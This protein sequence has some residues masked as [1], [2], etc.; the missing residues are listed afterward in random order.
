MMIQWRDYSH[1]TI[2]SDTI[3]C[4]DIEVTSFW[5]HT[6]KILK[7]DNN[8]SDDFYNQECEKGSVVYIWMLGIDND[9]YYGREW[10]E[11]PEFLA[12][13]K[14]DAK[15]IRKKDKIY[16]YVHNLAYEFQFMQ[17]FGWE[18]DNV[19][20]RQVRKPMKADFDIFQF[21]C[22]YQLTHL[23]LDSW[24]K[25]L[26]IKKLVGELDYNML[27]SPLTPLFDYELDYCE[28]DIL[29]MQAGLKKYR[30]KYQHISKIPLTSTGEVRKVV[31]SIYH[32]DVSYLRHT[33]KCMPKTVE[34]YKIAKSVFGGGD[35]HAN[36]INVGKTIEHCKG[37]DLS[38]SYPF[39][40]ATGFFPMSRFLE[41][42]QRDNFDTKRFCFIFFI[43]LSDAK[44]R[45]TISYIARSRCISVK[46]GTYDNGRVVN[47]DE[48]YLYCTE[49]DL[50]YI[51]YFYDAKLE[52]ISVRRAIKG[53]LDKRYVE[54]ILELFND[55]TTL[56]GVAGYEDLY[57]QQKAYLNSLFGMMVTDI[58]M[59]EI[60][61]NNGEWT[62]KGQ[63]QVDIAESLEKL[64]KNWYKNI[65]S[66]YWGIYVTSQARA[67]LWDGIIAII[68]AGGSDDIIYYDTDSIK[69]AHPD[70]YEGIFNRLNAERYHKLV[71]SS[72]R[73]NIPIERYR[74]VKPDGYLSILGSWEN[75]GN[76]KKFAL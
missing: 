74:P 11:L 26:G 45:G 47:A 35:T 14:E 1:R 69:Y 42:N 56:K 30:D 13:I 62:A 59:P 33:T 16:I 6:G 12:V 73:Y 61:F 53:Y 15:M 20:A 54:Y 51:K 57:M 24:G 68:E 2:T 48:I 39:I 65:L 34:D 29:I 49:Y 52:Y 27:R 4:L 36:V 41:T 17:C 67:S 18:W 40:M 9:I 32:K 38:S 23:S 31:R 5:V 63:L 58:V 37:K 66:Y 8:L 10:Q 22:S 3:I 50:E 72:K 19:F 71:K 28:H 60:S 25:Q 46:N 76:Y 55:K 70:N 43:K 44:L 7:W 64:H 21:R 75:D